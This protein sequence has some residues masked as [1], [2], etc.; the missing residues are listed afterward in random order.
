MR[1]QAL[2][3]SEYSVIT[4]ESARAQRVAIP[5]IDDGPEPPP[6]MRLILWPEGHVDWNDY[7]FEAIGSD[8][9]TALTNWPS[10]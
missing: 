1:G 8:Q 9:L 7:R 4:S 10:R 5:F 2:P 3:F 6:Q